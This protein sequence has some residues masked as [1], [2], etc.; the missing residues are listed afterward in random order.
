MEPTAPEI[1]PELEPGDRRFFNDAVLRLSSCGTIASLDPDDDNAREI[2]RWADGNLPRLEAYFRALGLGLRRHEEFSII[3]LVVEAA[4][5]SHP[6]R[7]RLDKDETG[8]LVALWLLHNERLAETVNFRVIVTVEEI[9]ARLSSLFA[10]DRRLPET[11]L[12]AILASFERCSLI[13]AD[14]TEGDGFAQSQI[15]L[16]PTIPST[17]NF[18]DPEDAKTAVDATMEPADVEPDAN[19]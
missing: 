10:N 6:L 4:E 19:E 14:L 7:R 1:F 2:F 11:R 15:L 3:Q 18:N 8:V 12:R 17:F 13:E 9:Y 16:L 5:A